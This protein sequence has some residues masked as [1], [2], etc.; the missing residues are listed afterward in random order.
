MRKLIV[1]ILLLAAEVLAFGLWFYHSQERLAH[2]A[3]ERDLS[4]ISKLKLASLANWRHEVLDDLDQIAD[5]PEVKEALGGSQEARLAAESTALSTALDF[6]RRYQHYESIMLVNDAGQILASSSSS[7]N[8]LHRFEREAL[9]TALRT[10]SPAISKLYLYDQSPR[11]CAVAPVHEAFRGN[12]AVTH[13]VILRLDPRLFLYPLIRLFPG[14][15]Q[16]AETILAQRE[17]DRVVILNELRFQTNTA[18]KLSIP[19]TREGVS[20]VMAAAGSEG[21]VSALDY[22][23]VPVLAA[24]AKVPDTPWLMSTEVDQSEIFADW[25]KEARLIILLT[26]VLLALLIGTT[27]LIQQWVKKTSFERLYRAEIR[28]RAALQTLENSKKRY[29]L[30]ATCSRDIILQISYPDGQLL[31]AN[32]AAINAYGYSHESLLTKTIFELRFADTRPKVENQ[33]LAAMEHGLLFESVH[34]RCDGS[35]FPVEVSSQGATFEGRRVLIT[36]IRDMTARKQAQTEL[37]AAKKRLEDTN[38]SLEQRVQ[39]RTRQLFESEERL[40]VAAQNADIGTYRYD[41]TT[42]QVQ[43]SPE[44]KRLYGVA[45][46]QDMNQNLGQDMLPLNVLPADRERVIAA[47]KAASHPTGDGRFYC[48]HR[49][50]RPDGSIR[51][52][53][54]AGLTEFGS[55]NGVL[56]PRSATGA[57]LDITAMKQTEELMRMNEERYRMLFNSGSD[58][59]FVRELTDTQRQPFVEVNDVACA[60]FGYSRDELLKMSPWDLDATVPDERVKAL[61]QRLRAGERVLFETQVVSRNGRQFPVELASQA[62]PL[63]GKMMAMEIVRD[64]SD[65]KKA[66]EELLKL[67]RVVEQSPTPIVLTDTAA[68]ITYVNPAFTQVTGYTSADVLGQ[69]PR[70]LKSGVLPPEFYQNLWNTLR[71]GEVWRGEICNKKKNGDFFWESA[72][73]APVR[74]AAGVVTCYAGIKEDITRT[75]QIESELRQAKMDADA[76]NSAKSTFLANMSHE[77]RTPLNAILGYTQLLRRDSSLPAAVQTKLGTINRSGEHLLELVNDVLE[78]AKIEAGRISIEPGAF[79]LNRLLEDLLAMF[80]PQTEAKGLSLRLVRSHDLPGYVMADEGRLRQ[81]LVNLCGNAVKFT[82]QGHVELRCSHQLDSAGQHR[83]DIAIAD[84]G[85]G[86]APA[87]CR[88]LFGHFE[89]IRSGPTA[90]TGTGLGLAISREY[91]RL[92]G[93]D[94]TVSSREGHGSVFRVKIPVSLS[95]AA[96]VAGL[97]VVR[98]VIGLAPGQAPIR[99]LVVDDNESNRDWLVT[100]LR[101]MNFEVREAECGAEAVHLCTEWKPRL[102]LMDLRMPGMDGY[103]ATRRIKGLPGGKEMVVI[104]LTASA[105]GVDFQTARAAGAVEVL[106]KPF[107]IN[108]LFDKMTRH[109]GIR[110][111]YEEEASGAATEAAPPFNPARL[112]D[113]PRALRTELREAVANGDQ[114]RIEA[115][116]NDVAGHDEQAADFLRTL[117]DQ[118]DYDQ[119]NRHLKTEARE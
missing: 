6:F 40:R 69:N 21:I 103:E 114:A 112:A 109:L 48:E 108:T 118:Y 98:R 85:I 86:I 81:I 107:D 31:E 78:M 66:E 26:L 38:N 2:Q 74:N 99:I 100:L 83:L 62:F 8:E 60:W 29:A 33:M 77:I 7:T 36:V 61:N 23:G 28:E 102:V 22:R 4:Y 65:R 104:A 71:A 91:A 15:S 46:D 87:D 64:V 84:S 37:L 82:H 13:A 115:R 17:G 42:R 44:Y 111:H 16:S 113:L 9:Q 101:E 70:L 117:A 96:H 12:S 24:L 20:L 52:I 45:P 72:A 25:R 75:K 43:C 51:W 14:V 80:R 105:V 49:I 56:L 34:R 10:D 63:A 19:M 41:F 67:S 5:K 92:M 95:S 57:A 106:G 110:F 89:Q 97:N 54:I 94:I 90:Q 76:A 47:V 116:L 3:A 119:L 50:Q 88:R 93:G 32:L 1:V 68:R 18:A 55:E 27:V 58:A 79:D 73:I 59:I 30:L 39:E 53:R 11:L 35:L